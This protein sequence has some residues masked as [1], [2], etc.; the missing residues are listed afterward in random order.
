MPNLRVVVP[1]VLFLGGCAPKATG[2]DTDTEDTDA[3][4]SGACT[5]APAGGCDACTIELEIHCADR[6]FAEPGVRV[7]VAAAGAWVVTSGTVAGYVLDVDATGATARPGVPSWFTRAQ[8]LVAEDAE[9]GLHLLAY[10]TGEDIHDLSLRYAHPEAEG[11]TLEEVAGRSAEYGLALGSDGEARVFLDPDPPGHRAVARRS[12]GRWIVTSLELPATAEWGEFTLDGTGETI[13]VGVDYSTNVVRALVGGIDV[14][15]SPVVPY[16]STRD[17]RIAQPPPGVVVAG[18]PL[19]LVTSPA[20]GLEVAFVDGESASVAIPGA[21]P[22]TY[23]CPVFDDEGPCPGP[24][25]ETGVGVRPHGAEY[26]AARGEDGA[27]WVA[28]VVEHLDQQLEYAWSDGGDDDTPGCE[29]TVLAD[30]SYQ[31]LHVVRVAP[32][33][34]VEPALSVEVEMPPQYSGWTSGLVNGIDLAA[35][36]GVVALAVRADATSTEDWGVDVVRVFT[37]PEDTRLE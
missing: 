8:T 15:V 21:A 2:T 14:L 24:C 17:W 16:T 18:A 34:T 13:A 25:H 5:S 29:G 23:T 28:Y 30:E 4:D 3:E 7:G 12:P 32:E 20:S 26:A 36:E 27:V 35:A 9:D 11:W 33:G 22:L 19:A 37:F 10:G 6:E 31:T 1:L